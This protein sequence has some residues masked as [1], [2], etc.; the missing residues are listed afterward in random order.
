MESSLAFDYI[1]HSV[2]CGCIHPAFKDMDDP[3]E[4]EFVVFSTIDADG[5]FIPHL[6][7]CDSC[8]AM[9][10]IVEVGTKVPL[11]KEATPSLPS[12]DDY[13]L[14]LP[15][16]LASQLKKHNCPLHVWQEA[17]FIIEKELWDRFVVL[18]KEN[19]GLGSKV[20][21]ILHIRGRDSFKIETFEDIMV[22]D[23][24]K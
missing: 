8:G 14:S 20:G 15:D 24:D 3:P 1:K 9:H 16:K 12:I 17:S 13:E 10:R 23:Y 18:T 21:K 22:I 4:H 7:Q 2:P 5:K 6:S 19:S 11:N